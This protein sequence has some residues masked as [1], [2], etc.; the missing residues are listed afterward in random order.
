MTAAKSLGLLLTCLVFVADRAWAADA[1]EP[2][3]V[4]SVLSKVLRDIPGKEMLMMTVEY[5]PGGGD[6]VHRHDAH[7]FVYV[8]EGL[9]IMQVE[10]GEPVKLSPGQ[11]FYEGPDDVHTVG[12]NASDTESAKFLV[13]LLKDT[14]VAPLLPVN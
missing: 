9:I 2:P 5:P 11:T 8:L 13:V 7:A 10:G 12:R 6:P 14:G 3:D 4:V 1:L